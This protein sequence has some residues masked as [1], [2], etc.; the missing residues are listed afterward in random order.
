M[1]QLSQSLEDKFSLL[2]NGERAVTPT[3]YMADLNAKVP[4]D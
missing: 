4:E 3:V 1:C 2:G